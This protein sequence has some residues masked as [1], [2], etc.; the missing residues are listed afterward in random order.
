MVLVPDVVLFIMAYV[1]MSDELL[2][3]LIEHFCCNLA[4]L[5]PSGFL[6]GEEL[7]NEGNQGQLSTIL[8]GYERAGSIVIAITDTSAGMTEEQLMN[9]FGEGV[10]FNANKLQAGGG[11]GLGLFITK[12]LVEQH[13]GR[14]WASSEG[15]GKGTTF[16]IELPAFLPCAHRAGPNEVECNTPSTH[17]NSEPSCPLNHGTTVDPLKTTISGEVQPQ[18]QPVPPQKP[19][20]AR[21]TRSRFA[22]QFPNI[23]I[24]DDAISNRKLLHRLLTAKGFTC[25]QAV[26]GLDALR[27]YEEV[28]RQ[29]RE[30]LSQ[31]LSEDAAKQGVGRHHAEFFS[32]ILMDFEMPKMDGPTATRELRTKLGCTCLIFGVTGNVLPQDVKLFIEHGADKVIAKPLIMDRLEKTW[33][34]MGI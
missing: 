1:R 28:T 2:K 3:F 16:A 29:H 23:L 7:A 20:P 30:Q 14:I 18:I 9:M 15:L 4:F 6:L 25:H 10:Q 11:S 19:T 13:G 26:D 8:E 34:D 32:T 21:S 27:V 22:D 31:L 33:E 5:N 17:I 12:G 24:V